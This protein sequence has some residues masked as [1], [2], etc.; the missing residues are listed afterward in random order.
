[1]FQTLSV[2]NIN[3]PQVKPSEAHRKAA[4]TQNYFEQMVGK[5]LA[6]SSTQTD[7][8][9]LTLQEKCSRQS[10]TVLNDKHQTK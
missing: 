3:Y 8:S 7:T 9:R 6:L 1:M 4:V 2:T 5:I 10:D